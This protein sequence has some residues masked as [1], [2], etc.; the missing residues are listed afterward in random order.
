MYIPYEVHQYG[1]PKIAS[2][3]G[4][5][6]SLDPANEW[7]LFKTLRDAI[8]EIAE[9]ANE[10]QKSCEYEDEDF[11]P[12]DKEKRGTISPATRYRV[13][14]KDGFECVYCKASGK[15]AEL[16]IDHI[17][18]KSVGGTDHVSNLQTLC[19]ECNSSKSGKV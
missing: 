12:I 9:K 19:R 2:L 8:C 14:S 10:I 4:M 11:Y 13:M 3:M 6:E 16:C 15:N 7:H 18:P 5:R 1:W 17:V